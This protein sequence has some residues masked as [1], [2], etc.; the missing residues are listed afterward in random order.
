M[1]NRKTTTSQTRQAS[2][3]RSRRLPGDNLRTQILHAI[4][5][6]WHDNHCPPTIREICA[7]V[8]VES[9]SHVAYHI[10]M[11]ER[12]GLVSRKPGKS[13]GVMLTQPSGLPIRGT[14]AAGQPLDIFDEGE[15]DML[16]FG[17]LGAAISAIPGS[18]VEGLYALQVRGD[19]MIED[20]ILSG[21]YVVIARDSK[22]ENGE[23]GVA[24]HNTANGGRGAATLKHI[25]VN[26]DSVR[27][28]PANEALQA[29]IVPADEW[30]REWSVQGTVVAVHR[31]FAGGRMA[32]HR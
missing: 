10:T 28:Q 13:R 2:D 30:N 7:D 3:R 11:L 6:Y 4:E 31:Q 9:T 16:G 26:H 15:S 20:G 8:N 22:V 29:R 27:L 18:V 17:E 1:P 25:F 5:E 24:V 19:S 32:T 21:D 14:I 12:Q 23:I